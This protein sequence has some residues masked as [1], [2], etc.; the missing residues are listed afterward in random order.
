MVTNLA[1]HWLIGLPVGYWLCFVAGWGARGLW[2]GLSAG[3]IVAG[4]VLT[5]VWA[6]SV[7]RL[8]GRSVGFR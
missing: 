3:L 7:A 8:S 5:A 6:R 1:A 4:A 2:W